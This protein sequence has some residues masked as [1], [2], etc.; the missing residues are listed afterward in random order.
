[1]HALLFLILKVFHVL[2]FHTQLPNIDNVAGLAEMLTLNGN[3]ATSWGV[4]NGRATGVGW[5]GVRL[6]WVQVSALSLIS[7]AAGKPFLS[8]CL[9]FPLLQMGSP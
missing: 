9:S 3:T 5:G 8:L 2:H 6:T 7:E 1:M 4:W